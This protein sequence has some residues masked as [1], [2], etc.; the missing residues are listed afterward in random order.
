MGL[1]ICQAHWL[2][3]VDYDTA[4]EM[5]ADF[6]RE[7]AVGSRPPTILLLEHPPVLTIGR[8]GGREHILWG[9]E[10]LRQEGII[11]REVD[12]GGDVT[13][14]GP[15]QL[16]GYPLLPLAQPGWA[17]G[18]LP[19]ADF[20]GYLRKLEE[21]LIVLLAELGIAAGQRAGLTG[22]W[23]PA[24]AWSKC[25]RCDPARKPAPAKI[26]SIGVKVDSQGVSRHGFALNVN[27][28]MSHWDAIIPCGLD[29]VQMACVADFREPPAME[30]MAG[31]AAEKIASGLGFLLDWQKMSD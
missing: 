10:K 13:F 29:G 18:H 16:V 9:D 22:V 11:V 8:R 28:E 1:P 21:A 31:L 23:V 20:T 26:A 17:G 6:A 3:L 30:R 24:D 19:S 12:R 14:H 4:W 5:Q 15:G 7:I 25:P 2:G 27:P